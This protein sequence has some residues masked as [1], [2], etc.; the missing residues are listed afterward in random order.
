MSFSRS[1]LHPLA[2]SLAIFAFHAV[3]QEPKP[4]VAPPPPSNQPPKSEEKAP[5]LPGD[6]HVSQ[7]I[8]LDG[9]PLAYTATV[10]TLPVY[11]G[12]GKK[13]GE[14]VYTAYTVEGANRPV[15]FALNGGPGASS[16]FLNFGAIGP[17]RI[18]FGEQGDSPSDPV[19]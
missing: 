17:K 15:T 16:V 18:R 9:K 11:D 8:E 3:A 13:S 1:R 2:L 12:T 14:V 6:A 7:T 19:T 4:V 5:P 10:G